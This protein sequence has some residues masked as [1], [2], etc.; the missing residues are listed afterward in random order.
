MSIVQ[1]SIQNVLTER[2]TC[3][4][5]VVHLSLLFMHVQSFYCVF[6]SELVC[7]NSNPSAN[8]KLYEC[9]LCFFK[10]YISNMDMKMNNLKKSIN[11]QSFLEG[12]RIKVLLL[13]QILF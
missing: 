6:R 11:P 12:C 10:G 3:L 7:W 9:L 1:L 5:N 8:L 13:P 2:Q 4:L